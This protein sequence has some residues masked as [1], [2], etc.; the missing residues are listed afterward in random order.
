MHEGI[1][2]T[3]RTGKRREVTN[4]NGKFDQLPFANCRLPMCG[5]LDL[6]GNRVLSSHDRRLGCSARR[7][8]KLDALRRLQL[9]N[10]DLLDYYFARNSF[11]PR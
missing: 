2:A 1:I 6:A 4:N 10:F 11:L 3:I 8:F 5:N 9:T 7:K